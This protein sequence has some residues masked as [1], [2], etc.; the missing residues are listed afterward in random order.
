MTNDRLRDAMLRNGL[1]PT[2]IAQRVGVD[3][4]TAERWIT[5]GRAPYPRY[6][7]EIAALVKEDEAYLWPGAVSEA[8]GGTASL[9]RS[10]CSSILGGPPYLRICGSG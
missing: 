5:Q 10:W 1:T 3:P 7:F 4:K 9:S 8:Q 6:R 2:A